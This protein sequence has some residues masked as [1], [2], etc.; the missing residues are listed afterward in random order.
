MFLFIMIASK[1]MYNDA[2]SNKSW[3]IVALSFHYRYYLIL[4]MH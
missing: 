3:N 2:Y 1:V 4:S